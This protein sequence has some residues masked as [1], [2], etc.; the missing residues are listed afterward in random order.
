MD[1]YLDTSTSRNVTDLRHNF[2]DYLRRHA[3]PGSDLDGASL[4]FGELVTNALRHAGGPAWISVDWSGP[5]PVITVQDLGPGFEL[6]IVEPD[7]VSEGGRGLYIVSHLAD[8]LRVAGK[9]GGGAAVSATLP[10]KRDTERSVDPPRSKATALPAP[11]EAV[12]GTFSREPFLRAL[13]VQLAQTV[14]EQHGPDAAEAA[15]AQVGTDVGSRIEDA[16]RA[17]ERVVGRLTP[18]QMGDLYVRLKRAIEGDFYVIEANEE[19]IVLGN[20]ACPFGEVVRRAPA[21]CR[22]T[23]AVFGGIAARNRGTA[24]VQLEERIAVGDPE[25]RVIVWL[26]E[27]PPEA[28]PFVHRYTAPED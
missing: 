8:E 21:L 28:A 4:I 19:R 24:A 27:P 16:W 25:C 6:E 11:E 23:S 13:V 10:V 14:E 7:L 5:Q 15:V 12:D 20:R 18:E 22:M 2:E 1:W 17:A 3:V 26:K 9:R